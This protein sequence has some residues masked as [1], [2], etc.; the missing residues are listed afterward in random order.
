ML[1]T[2]EAVANGSSQCPVFA[3]IKIQLISKNL[4]LIFQKI[5]KQQLTIK[6]SSGKEFHLFPERLHSCKYC[7]K[8]DFGT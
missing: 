5:D 4:L 8:K 3:V 2:A 7:C 1:A 6:T